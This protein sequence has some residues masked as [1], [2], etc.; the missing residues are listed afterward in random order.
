MLEFVVG[1]FVVL[2]GLVHL[3]Y[4]GQSLRLFELRPGMAW[5]DGSWALSK[6]LGDEPARFLASAFCVLAAVGFAIGGTGILFRQ[7]W[8]R[9]LAVGSAAFSAAVF[10]LLWD[11]GT[12]E[13]A[14][15]GG[16]AVLINAAI[17]GAVVAVDWPD[18]EF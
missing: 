1:V 2:H 13:L 4:S 3:L 16:I 5:P 11:G 14:D 18:F 12:Q 7:A 17:L 10:V 8:W 9:L 15:K 6:L